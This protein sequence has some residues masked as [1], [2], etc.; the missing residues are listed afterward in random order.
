MAFLARF[1]EAVAR[2]N[3]A[4]VAELVHYPLRVN[5]PDATRW[6]DGV[7]Q[8]RAE[9][10]VLFPAEARRLITEAVAHTLHVSWRGVMFGGGAIWVGGVCTDDTVSDCPIGITALNLEG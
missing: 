3:I 8:F 7:Q 10:E 1:Q 9:Y 2:T 5:G 6:I 4:G